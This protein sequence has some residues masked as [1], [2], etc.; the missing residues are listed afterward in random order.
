MAAK[1]KT[2]QELVK[3]FDAISTIE[4]IA[5]CMAKTALSCHL[6]RE[7]FAELAFDTTLASNAHHFITVRLTSK[8]KFEDNPGPCNWTFEFSFLT[9]VVKAD[10]TIR[11]YRSVGPDFPPA[12]NLT[13]GGFVEGRCKFSQEK[14]DA[15]VRELAGD[16]PLGAGM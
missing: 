7:R 1:I 6:S 5:T 14:L 2:E 9:D 11:V 3:L 12:N 10:G 13:A 15:L 16:S 8:F 4:F